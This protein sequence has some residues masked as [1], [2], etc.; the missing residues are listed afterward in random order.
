[1]ALALLLVLSVIQTC[2]NDHIEQHVLENQR[3]IEALRERGVPTQ[4]H[5]GSHQNVVG[6]SSEERDALQDPNNILK[7][8]PRPLV[9]AQK[10]ARGGTLRKAT[11]SDPPGLNPY[12]SHN[13]ADLGALERY[14]GNHLATRQKED[15]DVWSPELAIKVTT[16]DGGASYTITLRK[17]VKWQ[18][19]VV[20]WESGRF[21]WLKGDHELTSDDF[22][23]VFDI[24]KNAQTSGRV[25]ALRNYYEAFDRYEVLDRYRFKVFWKEKL[26]TN[27]A[28]MLDLSPMPRWLYMYDEDGRKFD[29]ATWG[30]KLN[31]HWYNQKMIGTG[32]YRFVEWKP[33]VKIELARNEAYWG[34]APAFDRVVTLILKDQNAPPR[35]LKA[36][37]IDYSGLAP[38]QYRTIVLERKGPI[39]GHKDIN[40][41]IQPSLGY[42]YIGWNMD[43]P[44]FGDKR[45]RQAMTMALDRK[46]IIDN[47]FYGLGK[48]H[49]GPFAQQSPCY[50]KSVKPWPYDLRAAASKLEEAGWR[51]TNKDGIRE[52]T[53]KGETVPFEFSFV[54]YGSSTEYQ[55]I[56]NIYR[57]ALLQIGVRM[58][59][60]PLEWST[61]LKKLDEKEFGAFSGGWVLD[62]DTDLFQLWHSSEADRPKSSNRVGFRNKRADEIAEQLRREFDMTKRAALCHEFHQLLHEEQP[63]T[64]IYQRESAILYW[65]YLNKLEHSLIWPWQDIRYQSF[66]EKRP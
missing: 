46:S 32:P 44:M 42:F 59:P 12:V 18:K 39:L 63:Y 8:N 17:G 62:W 66:K 14:M 28:S 45:V 31:E 21:D 56:S 43:S 27:L 7:P 4:S 47:V 35:R 23:F 29:D 40:L 50:D 22:A 9:V 11:S 34:E 19:P 5:T 3:A 51:D 26:F 25:S 38:E 36:G 2:Q 33:G 37:A 24:L 61:M 15:P 10:V 52:K 48:L 20:D 60:R 64:F 16:E 41:I 13:A 57:E 49:T 1:M 53:V 54:T 65:D 6:S 30:L 58:N 55:T